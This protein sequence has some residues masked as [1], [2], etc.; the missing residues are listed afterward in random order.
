MMT[1]TYQPLRLTDHA[2]QRRE[3]MGIG[4][5]EIKHALRNPDTVY[6]GAPGHPPGRLC[7]QRGR[8]VVIVSEEGQVVTLLWHRKENR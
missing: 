6:P 5:K 8:L 4:T 7:Y 1:M 3:E 2:Q